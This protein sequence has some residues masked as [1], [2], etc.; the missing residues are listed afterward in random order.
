MRFL[1]DSFMAYPWPFWLLCCGAVSLWLY[2]G[3]ALL[4][5]IENQSFSIGFRSNPIGLKLLW[6]CI[7]AAYVLGFVL[8]AVRARRYSQATEKMLSAAQEL[9]L[10]AKTYE[11]PL[12]PEQCKRSLAALLAVR[13]WEIV[14]YPQAEAGMTASEIADH[15]RAKLELDRAIELLQQSLSDSEHTSAN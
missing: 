7:P 14:W 1:L 11:A 2:G 8:R 13:D 4:D 9:P 10:T 3:M 12:T 5:D 15:A 6:F